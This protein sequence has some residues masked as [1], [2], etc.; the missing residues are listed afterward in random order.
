MAFLSISL[1]ECCFSSLFPFFHQLCSS[2][3]CNYS[4]S[5]ATLTKMTVWWP[6]ILLLYI[7]YNQSSSWFF[8]SSVDMVINASNTVLHCW[9]AETLPKCRQQDSKRSI[10][11]KRWFEAEEPLLTSVCVLKD[12]SNFYSRWLANQNVAGNIFLRDCFLCLASSAW[13]VISFQ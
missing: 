7:C 13:W 5:D 8:P 2:Q 11:K 1:F 10:V 9:S 3:F 12:T 6:L 4:S